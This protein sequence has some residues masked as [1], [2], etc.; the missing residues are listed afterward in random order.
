[1][2]RLST[3]LAVLTAFLFCFSTQSVE[4]KDP[5]VCEFEYEV[6]GHSDDSGQTY[7]IEV[8][9]ASNGTYELNGDFVNGASMEVCNS[10][11]G[12]DNGPKD[13]SYVFVGTYSYGN[14]LTITNLDTG[15]SQ[16]ITYDLPLHQPVNPHVDMDLVVTNYAG[17]CDEGCVAHACDLW[18]D[19]KPSKIYFYAFNHQGT[20]HQIRYK[21][22]HLGIYVEFPPTTSHYNQTSQFSGNT[23]YQAEIRVF[24]DGEWTDWSGPR[25]FTTL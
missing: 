21:K 18:V 24:C 11:H 22:K 9:I 7:D 19:P 4:A 15:C 3:M 2:L 16:T 23:E 5:C 25:F 10:C 13:A 17:A 20:L 1:M 8:Y 6:S 12:D 14:S